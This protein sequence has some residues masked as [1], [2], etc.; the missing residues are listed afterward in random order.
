MFRL[1][2]SLTKAP[3][4]E[5]T[6]V[7]PKARPPVTIAPSFPILLTRLELSMSYSEAEAKAKSTVGLVIDGLVKFER[8][9]SHLLHESGAKGAETLRS[10]QWLDERTDLRDELKSCLLA[11]FL[12]YYVV[13]AP[14]GVKPDIKYWNANENAFG[15]D[16]FEVD[17]MW[18][19]AAMSDQEIV[20]YL[21]IRPDKVPRYVGR[22]YQKISQSL[23]S[24]LGL[25]H[26][27]HWQVY[28]KLNDPTAWRK[29]VEDG[30]IALRPARPLPYPCPCR[31]ARSGPPE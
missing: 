27:R 26:D 12:N 6:M 4:S 5:F 21:M 17:V 13:V 31:R 18:L 23:H 30:S 24:Q 1:I 28:L 22:I 29:R 8:D 9:Y 7:E 16:R 14:E 15:L 25:G 19:A 3:V 2:R 10:I 11:A 20:D